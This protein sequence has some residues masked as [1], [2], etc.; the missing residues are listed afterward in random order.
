MEAL[1]KY[2]IIFLISTN[3]QTYIVIHK[4]S[5]KRLGHPNERPKFLVNLCKYEILFSLSDKTD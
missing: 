5:T 3:Q 2:E 1:V 4:F